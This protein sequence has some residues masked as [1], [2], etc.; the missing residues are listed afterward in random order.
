MKPSLKK[1]VITIIRISCD[2]QSEPK[3]ETQKKSGSDDKKETPVE[4]KKEVKKASS[5]DKKDQSKQ[6]TSPLNH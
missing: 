4:Q 6:S 3:K 5:G 1:M 2:F